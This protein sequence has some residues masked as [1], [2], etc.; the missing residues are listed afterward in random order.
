MRYERSSNPHTETAD[1]YTLLPVAATVP[2]T[3]KTYRCKHCDTELLRLQPTCDSCEKSQEWEQRAA[4]HGCDKIVDY[5]Q[6]ECQHCGTSLPLWRAL[7]AAIFETDSTLT[8]SKDGLEHP[9]KAGYRVHLGSV[10]G[11]WADYRR[12]VHEGGD[13]HVLVFADRYELHYDEVSAVETPGKHL[14]RHGLP[15]VTGM[16][17]DLAKQ[18]ATATAAS[19]AVARDALETS[20]TL[21]RSGETSVE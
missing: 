20:T 4:C 10:H 15:A 14:L 11:Q 18:I 2:A 1:F 7:E 19:G 17:V 16:G 6:E 5:T 3:A 21:F 8:L 9:T 13:F 12:P